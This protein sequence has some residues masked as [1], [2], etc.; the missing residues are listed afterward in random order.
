MRDEGGCFPA[1]SST[2]TLL[3]HLCDLNDTPWITVVNALRWRV[4]TAA[5]GMRQQHE[6]LC[7]LTDQS[8]NGA[9]TALFRRAASVKTRELN[10]Y[11]MSLSL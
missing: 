2:S 5:D 7:N 3:T 6:C 8:G 4:T 1:I 9:A 11:I 10:V